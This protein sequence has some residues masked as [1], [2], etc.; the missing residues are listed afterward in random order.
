MG[1]RDIVFVRM[2]AQPVPRV[3]RMIHA[4]KDRGWRTT[5]VGAHREP[6]LAARE[7]WE[8]DTTLRRVGPLLPNL[9]GKGAA[10]Y[11]YGLLAFNFAVFR[12]LLK[13]RP[14]VVHA[15]D[16]E[17]A[18]AALL[19]R[20]VSRARV[21]YNVHD[22]YADRYNLPGPVRAVL[23]RLEGL[24]VRASTVA[25]VP[26]PFRRDALP[27]WC[28][29]R[30]EVVRN[31]PEPLDV[32][33]P[34]PD[35]G[36]RP[37]RILYAGWIDAGRGVQELIDLADA[38]AGLVEV[39][40]AGSGD[41]ELTQRVRE[42]RA[43]YLGYVNYADSLDQMRAA[44]FIAAIYAPTRPINQMAA[45]NKIA[46]ALALG[47]PIV[48]NAEVLMTAGPEFDDCAI[49]IPFARVT[50]LATALADLRSAGPDEYAA[51]CDAARKAYD[52]LYSW[53]EMS[54]AMDNVLDS[55]G[56]AR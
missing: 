13:I 51:M 14:R 55:A 10:Q 50:E 52:S 35:F 15:S 23:N 40:I 32:T 21:I 25:L 33:L 16:L 34:N 53:Q 44:D 46:E 56:V 47:R 49:R 7:M 18:P 22:N 26:E 28:R 8:D 30:I 20:L 9:N 3:A 29:E 37:I 17:A 19:W 45:P 42:S 2:L 27:R 5:Y 43:T 31:A 39:V 1:K 6:G 24:A 54:A 36:Q 12:V 4:A 11:V 48:T 41:E 38:H